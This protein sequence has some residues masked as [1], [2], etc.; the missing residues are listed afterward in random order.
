[1]WGEEFLGRQSLKRQE[2]HVKALWQKHIRSK[3][4]IQNTQ[5]YLNCKMGE[6]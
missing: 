1:M 6:N 5:K 4:M 2:A 3:Q